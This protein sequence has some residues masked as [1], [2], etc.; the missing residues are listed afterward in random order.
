MQSG[1]K[2]EA[3]VRGNVP[4]TREEIRILSIAKLKLS[5]EA[6]L[7]DIGAGT[8]SVSVEAALHC[9]KGVVYAIERNPEGIRL[10]KENQEKFQVSNIQVVEGTAPEC[11]EDLP[12]PTHVFIGG[13]GGNLLSIIEK[14]RQKNP[15]VKFVVNAVTLETR[16]QLEQISYRFPVYQDMELIQVNIAKR[17]QLGNYHMMRAEYPVYIASFTQ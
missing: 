14:V 15:M 7:Y 3:F 11:L 4:M 10:I 6:V 1:M 13:S 2:D 12:V 5:E 9:T 17:A 8:G 16:M